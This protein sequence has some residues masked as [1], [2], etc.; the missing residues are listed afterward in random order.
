MSTMH[1]QE[2]PCQEEI[3]GVYSI[4]SNDRL[5][6]AERAAQL[7]PQ[8]H[9]VVAA[10]KARF[11]LRCEAAVLTD[12]AESSDADDQLVLVGVYEEAVDG[13]RAFTVFGAAV[14]SWWLSENP[15][16]PFEDAIVYQVTNA[17]TLAAWCDRE[18]R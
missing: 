1:P 9:A 10:I 7:P 14:L 17:A 12:A 11:G 15:S 16:A 18:R 3:S 6:C 5:A 2:T 4:I 13:D 8:A